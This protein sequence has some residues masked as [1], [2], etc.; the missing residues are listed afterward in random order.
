[1]KKASLMGPQSKHS[2]ELHLYSFASQRDSSKVGFILL[3][4]L[5]RKSDGFL[6]SAMVCWIICRVRKYQEKYKSRN[7]VQSIWKQRQGEYIPSSH[8]TLLIQ[9]T[10]GRPALL[11]WWWASL[12]TGTHHF[13]LGVHISGRLAVCLTPSHWAGTGDLEG[14]LISTAMTL[15]SSEIQVLHLAWHSIPRSFKCRYP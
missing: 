11:H 2:R 1:M 12:Y 8:S 6:M 13:P 10:V 4:H 7:K 14:P 3:K 5:S 15:P 9:Y